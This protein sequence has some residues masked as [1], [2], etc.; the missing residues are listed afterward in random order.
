MSDGPLRK[1]VRALIDELNLRTTV[2][3]SIQPVTIRTEVIEK[4]AQKKIGKKKL[5]IL[6]DALNIIDSHKNKDSSMWIKILEIGAE[7]GCITIHGCKDK[8]GDWMF[9]RHSDERTLIGALTDEEEECMEFESFSGAVKGWDAALKDI[10]IYP[11]T[12][13]YPLY[14]HPEFTERVMSE[15]LREST[16][17]EP[18]PVMLDEWEKV[19]AVGHNGV[20]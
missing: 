16:T 10:A 9:S 14:V 4:E 19:C 12:R 1:S 13:L 11:W 6:H 18:W 15:V 8:H 17:D 7:G 2:Y 20:K 3:D 5:K